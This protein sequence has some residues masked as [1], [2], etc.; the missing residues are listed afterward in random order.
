MVRL[1]QELIEQFDSL[2]SVF[3][4]AVERPGA[5]PP[6]KKMSMSSVVAST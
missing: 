2:W 5:A 3:R 1:D 6:Q 4:Q